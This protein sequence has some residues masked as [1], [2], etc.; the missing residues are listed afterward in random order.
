MAWWVAAAA[1]CAAVALDFLFIGRQSFW[2]DEGAS[3]YFT[4]GSL[5][6]L[7]HA[8][9][10]NDPNMTLYYALLHLWLHTGLGDS[11]AAI[12]ALSAIFAVLTLPLIYLLGS[13]LFGPWSGAVAAVLFASNSFVV[14]YAQLAR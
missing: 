13:R 12:R 2:E 7:A 6:G 8:V 9:W 1:T 14:E 10:R 5:G 3:W 4:H 11:E